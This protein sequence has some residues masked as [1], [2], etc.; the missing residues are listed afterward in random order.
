MN[1]WFPGSVSLLHHVRQQCLAGLRRH[2]NPQHTDGAA[3]LLNAVLDP[4]IFGPGPFL[5]LHRRRSLGDGDCLVVGF[6]YLMHFLVIQRELVSASLPSLEAFRQSGR[7]MLRIGIPAA[8]ANMMT[9][10]ASG[11]MTAIAAGFGGNA[12]VAYGVGARLE[13]MATLLVLA[14][15]SLPPLISQNYGAGRRTGSGSHDLAIRS[16][17][18][19]SWGYTCFWPSPRHCLLLCF[20]RI[21]RIGAITLFL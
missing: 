14:M 2:Q 8:G 7:D 13:P 15:S 5:E 6:V 19:G 17:A 18:C 11:V 1:V 16:S 20:L 10:L 21:T 4:S 12:V 3:G 9:P